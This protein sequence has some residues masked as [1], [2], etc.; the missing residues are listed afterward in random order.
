MLYYELNIETS[1]DVT[2]EITEMC[3]AERIKDDKIKAILCRLNAEAKRRFGESENKVLYFSDYNEKEITAVAGYKYDCFTSP[4]DDI[5]SVLGKFSQQKLN[6]K[7]SEVTVGYFENKVNQIA[8]M[9][10][11]LVQGR[12]LEG[13]AILKQKGNSN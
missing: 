11:Q 10:P 8:D 7:A 4:E 13:N 6:V 5:L 1:E 3:S 9:F 2:R 12:T